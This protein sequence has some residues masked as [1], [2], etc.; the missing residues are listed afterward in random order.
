MLPY[1]SRAR[2][3]TFAEAAASF[4]LVHSGIDVSGDDY[5][6]WKAFRSLWQAQRDF[7][8][9]EHDV[10]V[11]PDASA[12]FEECP[13]PWCCYEYQC[14]NETSTWLAFGLGLV[15]FRQSLIE[16]HP[17]VALHPTPWTGLDEAVC[18]G[19]AQRGETPHV[20]GRTGHDHH[21]LEVAQWSLTPD[22]RPERIST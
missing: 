21:Y 6:Y 14:H 11:P 10:V 7:V 5:A 8:I 16:R 15:R 19:L 17:T 2:D 20:H 22:G 18:G 4:G 13:K 12:S 1:T 3:A 9:I